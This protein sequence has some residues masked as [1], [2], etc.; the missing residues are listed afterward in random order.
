M[1]AEPADFLRVRFA[2][3]PTG[4]LHIGGARTVLFNWLLARKH[5]GTFILRIE[6]TDQARHVEDSVGKILDDLRWLGLLWDEGP[7]VGGSYGPYFQ[8]QRLATYENHARQ[9]LETG[10]AYY[11]F[12]TPEELAAMREKARAQKRVRS[13]VRPEPVPAVEQGLAAKA[14]GRSVVVRLK[15][16]Y[17]DIAVVD[18][19]LGTVTVAAEQHEDFVIVKSDGFPTYHFACVVDD[20]LMKIT[21]VL[22]GQE[23]LMNTPKHIALQRALGFS[24]PR[25][26]HLP[27]IFNIDGSK[28]SKR[29]KEKAIKS[30]LPPPEIDVHDFRVAGYLPEAVLNFIALLGWAPGDDREQFTLEELAAAFTIERVGRTN[31]RFDREKLLSF[32]TTWAA[33]L[34]PDR[35]LAAFKAFLTCTTNPPPKMRHADDDMLACVLRLCA[36][37]RTFADV[38]KK[39]GFLFA[40]D[41]DVVVDEQA[42]RKVLDK[43]E[44]AGFDI[45]AFLLPRLEA[46]TDW[47]AAALEA[48][49][50]AACEE[51]Q[52]KI[53]AVAQP[54]R[55][56]VSGSTISPG[57][58][59]T[60]ALLGRER[61]IARIRRCLASRV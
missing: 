4:Y 18:D 11:S 26:A 13:Y 24:T 55:V 47:S 50:Q 49:L 39:S 44:C 1:T 42:R 10:Q 58:G 54:L 35:V 12:E 19:I 31:A 20:E 30:G 56:A 2:P 6:D 41:A 40:A 14:A 17:E 52:V 38:V 8:S 28:M 60:V 51:K 25:Y 7:E 37:F 59:Q 48:L 27:V 5:G 29:D 21:H 32:N 9:L 22:R 61:T 43:N 45:L 3:S 46:A 15:M 33:K 16:P 53:G 36:G 34:A 57:I 23:H